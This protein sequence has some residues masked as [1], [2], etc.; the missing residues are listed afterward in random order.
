MVQI[1][2]NIKPHL[3]FVV[4][5][6]FWLLLPLVPLIAL[7]LVFM[8]NGSLGEQITAARSQ[9]E[10]RLSSLKSVDGIQPH[11][12]EA[13]STDID[14][15]T[16]AVK[17]ETLAEWQRFWNSQQPLRVWP[18]SLGADFV[19]R[20]AALKPDG[21]LPRKL[22]E[23]YQNSVRA[24]VRQVPAR[25][26]ADEAM[27][28]VAAQGAGP[29]NAAN[30][31]QPVR[32]NKLVQW[33][34]EDQARVYA[35][36]DWG[37]PPSTLQVV[38]AQE[39]L[40]VYGLLCDSIARVNKVAAG[41]YNA[42]IP[43][44][45]QLAIGYPAAEDDPGASRGGR[46][47][48]SLGQSPADMP[49]AEEG[50]P[51]PLDGGLAGGP[52]GRPPH[53]RFAG[54][55]GPAAP[56]ALPAEEGGGAPTA[57]PDD[58][59]KNWIYVDFNG[60]P[61]SAVELATV[62]DAVMVHLMPFV[63]RAVID[64]RHLDAWLVDLARAPVPIDVRQVRINAGAGQPAGIPGSGQPGNPGPAFAGDAGPSVGSGRRHDVVVELRGTVGL[65]T[66]PDLKVLGIEPAAA[67]VEPAAPADDQAPAPANEPLPAD[68]PAEQPPPPA[69]TPV[70]EAEPVPAAD[71]EAAPAAPEQNR[72]AAAPQPDAAGNRPRRRARPQ[73]LESRSLEAVT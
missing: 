39:E 69:A 26:G 9:I 5:H 29:A 14:A 24:I 51:P 56:L 3:D 6:H 63:I 66:P 70:P 27:V 67:A 47:L 48:V 18:N 52:A 4:K 54:G 22:L 10:S 60:K 59:L 40:W 13:W 33:S 43:L 30:P 64:E 34:P 49:M 35:S 16:N 72:P 1:H 38:L 21:K 71:A 23:R 58:A 36:F 45:Q 68:Q 57:S 44:V 17:R 2:D 12:N 41:P 55:Q 11:P 50:A 53:P 32:S 61:L 8:A 15:R 46:I 31:A 20:A 28:D 62:P 73:T 25:M 42:P 65:A 19:Q 7:P 37:K